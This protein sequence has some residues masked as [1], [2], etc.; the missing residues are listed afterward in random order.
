MQIEGIYGKCIF[1][2][3]KNGF[4]VFFLKLFNR[5]KEGDEEYLCRG[6]VGLYTEGIPLILEGDF[7]DKKDDKGRKIFLAQ[8]AS[9]GISSRESMKSFVLACLPSGFKNV[10]AEKICNSFEKN[11]I[12]YENLPVSVQKDNF[13]NVICDAKVRSLDKFRAGYIAKNMRELISQNVLY[14]KLS[15]YGV[16]YEQI[17][18]LRN[19]FHGRT[20]TRLKKD[21]Y[22][23]FY[24]M[25]LPFK[26]AD[27]YARDHGIDFCSKVRLERLL[28]LAKNC[29][30]QLGHCFLTEDEFLPFFRAVEQRYSAFRAMIPRNLILLEMNFCPYIKLMDF[31]NK[32]YVYSARLNDAEAVVTHELIRLARNTKKLLTKEQI[33]EAKQTYGKK[34]D[35][36]QLTTLDL[37]SDSEICFLIGGPGTGKTTT[38][39]AVIKTIQRYLPGSLIELCAPTGR[40]AQRMK[41]QT[42]M[43]AKTIHAMLEYHYIAGG[44]C[45]PTY[46]QN[47]KLTADVI[48]VDEF[49]MVG[50]ELFS[51]L[52]AAAKDGTKFIFVGDW[53]QLQP[54]EPGSVLHDMVDSGQF[55]Y[56][57]LEKTHR[58]DEGSSIIQNSYNI[59]WGIESLTE[60]DSTIIKRFENN[61]LA[62][63]CLM[64]T[65][66]EEYNSDRQQELMILVP[67]RIGN[68]GTVS[69]NG[70]IQRILHKTDEPHVTFGDN[71][72]YENDKV[73]TIKNNYIDELGYYNGDIWRIKDTHSSEKIALV[74]PEGDGLDLPREFFEDLSLAYATTVHKAQGSEAKT[75]IIY[76]PDDVNSHLI[77]RSL[78]YTA[79]TRASKKLI[80]ISSGDTLERFIKSETATRRNS[81]MTKRIKKAFEELKETA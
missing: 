44:D 46:N 57:K 76:L 31:E 65:F 38:L 61:D 63:N 9:I 62:R 43:E 20:T 41:E 18:K 22:D 24:E 6:T 33:E 75:C 78:L 49:S 17:I 37:L 58:Q 45:I 30:E 3:N 28:E 55:K 42:S 27:L 5:D 47:N 73:M 81:M 36:I 64:D 59:L 26:N 72:F 34:L 71:L 2:N 8:K 74:S 16:S 23:C 25:G 7:S 15:P 53:N 60:D 48:I 66:K 52:I 56:V 14:D 77:N 68:N 67:Q 40:A 19:T 69:I 10:A 39:D 13:V 79:T 32:S 54:V 4:S 70:E 50:L 11:G 29:M 12:T 51:R 80:I 21:P 35:D 1:H